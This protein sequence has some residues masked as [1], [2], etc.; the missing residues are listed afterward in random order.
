[1]A[2][3]EARILVVE[4]DEDI[5]SILCS[6]LIKAGYEV[7]HAQSGTAGRLLLD[8]KPNLILM[9]LMLP[10]M[11]GEELL[12]H[13][14]D[15]T[16]VIAVTSK[17]SIDDKVELL[18]RGCVDYITKPFNIRELLARV[19]A[20]L[21][22][23]RMH[24]EAGVGKGGGR[25]VFGDLMLDD[26]KRITEAAGKEVRLTRTEY[27]ILKKLMQSEG[28]VISKSELLDLI[29]EDTPDC[30]DSSL[31]VHIS[32]LRRKLKET[33]GKDY[34]EAVWGIGFKLAEL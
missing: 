20:A 22:V 6:E 9:D 25:Y 19:N 28:R 17:S 15:N 12:T 23:S 8:Q 10:G 3:S 32:N 24:A 4:D 11:S 13:V 33:G 34:I 1:M 16:P 30:V 18:S 14:K 2:D 27:A 26:D 7:L 21:R 29:R 31:K 5:G